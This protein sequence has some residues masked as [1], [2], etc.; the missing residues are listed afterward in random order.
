MRKILSTFVAAALS[1]AA[2]RIYEETPG[3]TPDGTL[4]TF[5][6]SSAPSPAT[7]KVSVNGV[8]NY[9]G[10][11]YDVVQGAIVFREAS[12]PKQGW[13]LRVDYDPLPL[14]VF[15]QIDAGGPG[16]QYFVG[17]DRC[18]A[19]GACSF[20]DAV[21]GPVPYNTIRY[22]F[23]MIPLVYRIPAPNGTCQVSLGFSEPNKT[24]AGQRVFTIAANGVIVAD[25]DVFDRAG[26]A[27]LP[28][29]IALA[30]PVTTG[31]LEISFTAKPGTW[32]AFVSSIA[33]TCQPNP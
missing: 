8:G 28:T 3:G 13:A 1:M 18:S 31:V 7:V 19:G 12:I 17:P 22:G 26:G 24:A 15:V 20:T 14:P 30:A 23:A 10:V 21:M 4:P 32:N 33:V 11:D 9:Q 25:V 27:H 5:T 16:D 29:T 2:A 6:L